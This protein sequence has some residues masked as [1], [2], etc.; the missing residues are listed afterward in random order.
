VRLPEL[1][2]IIGK[3]LESLVHMLQVYFLELKKEAP[4]RSLRDQ[5]K[6]FLYGFSSKA[7]EMAR[8]LNKVIY[9]I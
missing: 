6:M 5:I 7:A 8:E 4:V 2:K 9:N 1:D 3:V